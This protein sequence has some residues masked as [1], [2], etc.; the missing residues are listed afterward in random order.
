MTRTEINIMKIMFTSLVF[1]ILS[2]C[3][4]HNIV[5]KSF[6]G[7]SKS[8][9][10]IRVIALKNTSPLQAIIPELATHKAVL[11]GESH[12][13]YGNHLNQL[14]V[15]KGLYPLWKKMAI[16]LEFIQQPYQKALDD[17]IAGDISEQQMLR[18]TQWYERWRYDFRLYRPIFNY[19]KQKKIPLIA[20]NT[21]REIT[22]R[23]TKV[24][25][26]G[27]NKAERA[28][29]PNVIDLSNTTY[30]K[31]LKKVYSHHA[32]TSSKKFER[33]FEAQVAWDESMAARAAS[34]LRLH[35]DHR[36]V[37]LAGSGHIINRHGIPSR[38]ER[39]IGSKTAVVLN[40][41]NKSPHPDQGD[42][43]LFSPDA[44]LAKAGKMGIFMKDSKKG[45]MISQVATDSAG[46]KA[47][48][49]KSDIITAI[50]THP[51]NSIQDVK[52]I[53]MDKKPKE[54]VT[55]HILRSGKQRLEKELNLQ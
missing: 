7:N 31:R 8:K 16:G 39:R 12:T 23:I 53:M 21:P 9:H 52:I 51:T 40:S 18:K 4:S 22:K 25:I 44:T 3:S 37:I 29:L 15:I 30:R 6:S 5:S 55:L 42:Y 50:N 24:G 14:A 13:D 1:L 19:A 49:K 54:K 20:L 11:V 38:L 27:L 33:F 46:D 34:Y 43:L 47:G 36:I 28:Q 17:Y 35:P 41:N 45:V 2:A 48:L 32:K 26:K 10:P